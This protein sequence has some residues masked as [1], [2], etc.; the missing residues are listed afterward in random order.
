[1]SR[2]ETML[3]F[4]E[5]DPDDSFT[6]YAVALEYVSAK[7][8]DQALAYFT[9]LRRRDPEYVATYYQLGQTYVTLER[10]DE[11]EEAF[12]SGVAAGRRAG[13]LHAVSELAAALDELETLR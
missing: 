1:M 10:W 13:D 7:D 9:E 3:G 6:R 11:A 12:R 8:Y 2:L 4:L 5:Q